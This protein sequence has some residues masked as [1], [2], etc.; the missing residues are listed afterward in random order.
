M[1]L[2]QHIVG[3]FGHPRGPL[4]WLAGRVMSRRESNVE[5]TI[6]TVRLLGLRPEASVL[7]LGHGPGIGLAHAL[8]AAPNGQVV[9]LERSTAMSS[10]A[11]R[12]NRSAVRDGRLS[13]VVADA[14]RP[15]TDIGTFDAIFSS[16]V[17]LFW[18]D[19]VT[20]LQAWSSHLVPG[21][22]MAVTF[23]PPHPKA[24]EVEAIAAGARIAS[25][26]SAAGYHQVRT[27][28]IPI[29]DVPAVCVLGLRRGP[30]G[31]SGL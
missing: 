17:W 4:G 18:Q 8:A 30:D 2:R 7:E 11:A 12:R 5:R 10:M 24:D 16:N 26:L 3:Q 13:L 9:G 31:C 1:S 23:R 28:L 20:T 21:G 25:D 15:P 22:V 19:P 14:E 27:E 6:A 29:G